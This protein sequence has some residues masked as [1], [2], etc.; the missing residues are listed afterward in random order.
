MNEKLTGNVL[1]SGVEAGLEESRVLRAGPWTMELAGGQLRT[2]RIGGVEVVRR[3]YAAV[4][5]GFW[6]TVP[7]MISGMEVEE[8]DGGFTVRYRSEHRQFEADFVWDAE[9]TGHADGT[10]RFGF[11]GVA[12]RTFA[13]NRIGL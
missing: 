9:I 11:D 13:R 6:N 5:D 12:R 4:R 8:S 2:M 3:V 1:L 7:G 10:V